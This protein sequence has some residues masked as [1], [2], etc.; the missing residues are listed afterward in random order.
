MSENFGN[1]FVTITDEYGEEFNLEHLATTEFE[2]KLYM[3]FLPADID[4]EHDD[5]GLVILKV[6]EENDEFILEAIED[7]N[8][9]EQIFDVFVDILSGDEQL[10][11]FNE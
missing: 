3:A 9:L 1:D 11:E 8:E 7:E 5:Y 10:E 2:E 4:E 6:V